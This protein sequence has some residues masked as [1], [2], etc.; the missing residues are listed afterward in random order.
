MNDKVVV[1]QIIS[2]H[3]I[4]GQFKIK[5]FTTDP[6]DLFTFNKLFI[7][8]KYDEIFLKKIRSINEYFIVSCSEIDSR[9]KVDDILNK[10]ILINRSQ[11]PDIGD[12][13]Y[14]NDLIGLSVISN[15]EIIGPVISVN[16]FG[17][18]DLIEVRTLSNDKKIFIPFSDDTIEKVD[19]KKKIIYFLGSSKRRLLL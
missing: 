6:D 18:S 1:G 10:S 12:E 19:Q 7:D 16:N 3:G 2:A 5:S 4:Q 14:F 11:L 8:E 15:E 13:Y 17:S 9:N